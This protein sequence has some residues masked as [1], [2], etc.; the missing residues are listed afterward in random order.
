MAVT[1]H[2]A[3]RAVYVWMLAQPVE[4]KTGSRLSTGT[5]CRVEVRTHLNCIHHHP[6]CRKFRSD[7]VVY[8]GDVRRAHQSSTDALLISYYNEVRCPRPKSLQSE[9][10]PRQ[11]LKVAPISYVVTGNLAIDDPVSIKKETPLAAGPFSDEFSNGSVVAIAG[12]RR[13]R[14]RHALR[15]RE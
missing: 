2:Y 4:D 7:I 13:V 11:P 10:R 1:D 12:G 9:S 14:T 5:R 8:R 3:E 15:S 6:V